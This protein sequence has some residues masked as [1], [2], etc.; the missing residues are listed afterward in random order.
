MCHEKK[1]N[2]EPNLCH[3]QIIDPRF[4]R[5][6]GD[7]FYTFYFSKYVILNITR[8]SLFSV[9]PWP[10]AHQIAPSLRAHTKIKPPTGPHFMDYSK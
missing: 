10:L 1:P 6:C 7:I 3:T 4:A 2:D 5:D 8:C 9:A